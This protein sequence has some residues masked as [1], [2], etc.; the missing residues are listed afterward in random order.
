MLQIDYVITKIKLSHVFEIVEI[1]LQ[2]NILHIFPLTD[3]FTMYIYRY[4]TDI[5]R[6]CLNYSTGWQES[7]IFMYLQVS[8]PT[9]FKR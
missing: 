7:D 5:Q 3:S 6:T 9:W 1:T 2:R 4:A 8:V